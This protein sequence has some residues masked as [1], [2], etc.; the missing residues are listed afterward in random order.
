MFTSKTEDGSSEN[1]EFCRGSH[2]IFRCGEEAVNIRSSARV[3][4][5][6][7]QMKVSFSF[8]R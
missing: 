4:A 3:G 2:E 6:Q 5:Y 8:S 7:R 1:R